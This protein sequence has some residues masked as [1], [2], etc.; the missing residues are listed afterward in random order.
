MGYKVV[1]ASIASRKALAIGSS[2]RTALG[3]TVVGVSHRKHPFVYSR[4]FDEVFVLE[5]APRGG[6]EW[7]LA[8]LEVA[9]RVGAEVIVPVDFLDVVSL[10][11][12]KGRARATVAAPAYESV[13]AAS[14]KASL[15]GLLGDGV[16]PASVVVPDSS[17]V[18]AVYSLRPPLVV[19]GLSDAASPEFFPDASSAAR[20][21]AARAPC[22]VQEYVPGR[23]RGYEVVAFEGEPLLEFAHERVVEYDPGGGA[24]LGARGPV[25]D[26]ELYRL[27]RFVVSRLRWTGPLMV[28]L[29]WI[30]AEGRY[31]VIELNPKFW[32]S[33]DLPVSLGYH[34]PAVLVKAFLEGVEEA[35]RFAGELR[36]GSGE[37][38]WLLDGFR[39]MAKLPGTWL[40]MA[41]RARRSDFSLLDPARVALQVV[42]AAKRL[43]TEKSSWAHSLERD[44]A[45]LRE[46]YRGLFRGGRPLVILDFDGVIARLHVDWKRVYRV[47]EER[48]YRR[49]WETVVGMF[50]RLWLEDVYKFEEASRTVEEFERV[51]RA[52]RI[53][54]EG[55]LRGLD[56][57]VASMQPESVLRK[58]IG[59]GV[60]L[61]RDSG[62]GP[63]KS[64]MFRE[65]VRRAGG[66][67]PVVV[68]D[69]DLYNCVVAMRMGFYPVR[70][71]DNPYRAVE[72]LRLGILPVDTSLLGKFLH[73]LK[74][75]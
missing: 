72:A 2:L 56:F 29:K 48:S 44:Y 13:A 26:P 10:S 39:Y 71:V 38:Y 54:D 3:A 31:F 17:G 75:P 49:R 25:L 5:G 64:E 55:V 73:K 62:L 45:K 74:S 9:E 59:E 18:D 8:V 4:L 52:E 27:G 16:V 66:R 28:E 15:G 14:N 36:V 7:G 19:K 69:D 24:S 67:G 65:C 32:G 30:P 23:G 60:V 21:A 1:L 22:L 42:A 46:F 53:L 50:R 33:L 51:A 37:F 34:F 20:A 11:R 40:Y 68:F 41:R 43:E 57:C 6:L 58:F 12:V 35:R 63:L 70:V 61:G 47:L